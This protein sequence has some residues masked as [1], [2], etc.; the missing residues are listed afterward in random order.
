MIED[1]MLLR[2]PQCIIRLDGRCNKNVIFE[3]IRARLISLGIPYAFVVT[4]FFPPEG[5]QEGLD[6]NDERLT[7]L[8]IIYLFTHIET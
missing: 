8:H 6:K 4:R 1:S 2:D 5:K 3:A 7:G